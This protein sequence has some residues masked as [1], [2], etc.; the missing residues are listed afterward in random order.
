MS[1]LSLAYVSFF[2]WSISHYLLFSKNLCA[3]VSVCVSTYSA[4]KLGL[5][6]MLTL[7]K[8]EENCEFLGR[9]RQKEGGYSA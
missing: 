2:P 6:S 3:Y 8:L 7:K 1:F 5:H 4:L 9:P